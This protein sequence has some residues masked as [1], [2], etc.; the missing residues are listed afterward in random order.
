MR[1]GRRKHKEDRVRSKG[2]EGET[3]VELS[4]LTVLGKRLF[5]PAL[6]SRFLQTST[7]MIYIGL[8]AENGKIGASLA[9]YC[10]K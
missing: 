9:S 3:K 6:V 8:K 10:V 5:Y 7:V 4:I 1:R 2:E